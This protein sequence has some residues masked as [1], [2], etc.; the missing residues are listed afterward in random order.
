MIRISG[1]VSA[2]GKRK[3]TTG[4]TV[5]VTGE[6]IRLTNARVDASGRNGGGRVLIGGDWGGGIPTARWSNNPSA[7]LESYFISTATR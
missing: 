1:T 3:G 4:G 6:D 2:A 5:L 7:R